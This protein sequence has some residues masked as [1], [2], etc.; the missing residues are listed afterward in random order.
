MIAVFDQQHAAVDQ[1]LE[2]LVSAIEARDAHAV[3][4]LAAT[5]RSTI[6]RLERLAVLAVV[7]TEGR[8]GECH[9]LACALQ[10]L[11]DRAWPLLAYA[12][13]KSDSALVWRHPVRVPADPL[14]GFRLAETGFVDASDAVLMQLDLT[15]MDLT[16]SRFDRTTLKEIIAYGANAAGA[17]AIKA[18]L[19]SVAFTSA[20]LAG[21]RFNGCLAY[22]S[23]FARSYLHG[24]RWH[25]AIVQRCRFTNAVLS[26]VKARRATFVDCDLR[27]VNFSA[28]RRQSE[29]LDGA[30]FIR[31]DLRWT[32]WRN[33]S[34]ADVTLESCRLYG[35]HGQPQLEG[36]VLTEPDLSIAG[37]GS[38]LVS[39]SEALARWR[40]GDDTAN[41][42]P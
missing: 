36:V 14:A 41:K 15:N 27:H 42:L 40:V 4:A 30:R 11:H 34:L 39:T 9:R 7:S 25:S 37:D 24:S 2:Q 16:R 20:M 3:I 18:Q 17:T 1:Q 33:R 26:D 13:R 5:I 23:D 28:Y 8:P 12:L 22:D 32:N 10:R 21:S 29:G 31:C 19:E 35:V 38:Y 6:E